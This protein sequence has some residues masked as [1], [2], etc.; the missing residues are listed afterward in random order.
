MTERFK[1]IA[2]VYLIL[3]REGRFLLLCRS[4]TGYGDGLYNLPAGHM[5]GGETIEQAAKR[6]ALEEIGIVVEEKDLRL[7]SMS[8]RYYQSKEGQSS[9]VFD[10]FLTTDKWRGEI[11]NMEPHKC[12]ELK[13][14]TFEE[15]PTTTMPYIKNVLWQYMTSDGFVKLNYD[16]KTDDGI[17]WPN[18]M[19]GER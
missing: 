3:E 8:H 4:G 6:E 12:S 7:V 18:G 9:E 14:C 5:D 15:L 19:K 17:S 1:Y 16:L 13:W 11:H 10:F 2:A